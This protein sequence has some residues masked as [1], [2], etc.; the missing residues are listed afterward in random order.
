MLILD[1]TNND[2]IYNIDDILTTIQPE[3]S[4]IIIEHQ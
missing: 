1:D 2:G 4:N 3:V